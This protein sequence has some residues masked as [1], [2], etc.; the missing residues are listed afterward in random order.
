MCCRYAGSIPVF[1]ETRSSIYI[2]TDK[3]YYETWSLDKLDKGTGGGVIVD[4]PPD[5]ICKSLYPMI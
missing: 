4:N 2:F 1:L 5:K 3:F